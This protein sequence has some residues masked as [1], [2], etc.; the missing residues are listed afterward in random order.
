MKRTPSTDDD[1]STPGAAPVV[2]NETV[3]TVIDLEASADDDPP[4]WDM[5]SDGSESVIQGGLLIAVGLATLAVESVVRAVVTALGEPSPPVGETT[6]EE[7]AEADGADLAENLA[8]MAGAGLSLALDAARFFARTVSGL[9]RAIR[10]L[11]LVAMIPPVDRAAR[12]LER[13]AVRMNAEWRHDRVESQRAAEAFADALVP[14]LIDAVIDRLDLTELVLERVDL[15]RVVQAVAIDR[16]LER[17]DLDDAVAQV[18]IGL[19]IDRVDIDSV[20]ARVDVERIVDRL[21]LVAIARG[22]IDELDLPTIIRESTESMAAE[23]RDGVRVQGMRAD[24]FVSRV[25]DRALLRN[26]GSSPAAAGPAGS[27]EDPP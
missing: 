22:V 11:S 14:H 8:V 12:G 1:E 27:I 4:P 19:I 9:D 24:R 16:V 18:D 23:T 15:D 20:A 26:E 21:D 25:V 13:S 7:D 10:P 6:D 2:I 3:V 5:T 17:V